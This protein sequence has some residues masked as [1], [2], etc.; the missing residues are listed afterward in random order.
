MK[1]IFIVLIGIMVLGT[2][3]IYGCRKKTQ[4]KKPLIIGSRGDFEDKLKKQFNDWEHDLKVL[5]NDAVHLNG[6]IKVK[7]DGQIAKIKAHQ[8]KVKYNLEGIQKSNDDNWEDFKK[9]A[10]ELKTQIVEA[11][12]Q[13]GDDMKK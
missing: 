10:E 9:A 11:F 4:L 12:K 1:S 7:I 8:K 2:L 5:E 6:D 3:G 13:A